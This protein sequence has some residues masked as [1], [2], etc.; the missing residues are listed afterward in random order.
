MSVVRTLYVG[1]VTKCARQTCVH[2][3]PDALKFQPNTT[4]IGKGAQSWVVGA[5]GIFA[6]PFWAAAVVRGT[7]N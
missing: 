1:N 6:L 3:G 5:Y 4:V 7:C 2:L